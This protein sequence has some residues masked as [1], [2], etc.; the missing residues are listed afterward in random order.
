MMRALATP[1]YG[2][3]TAVP[4]QHHVGPSS[5]R[6]MRP[7]IVA[8]AENVREFFDFHVL[9]VCLCRCMALYRIIF[10][11]GQETPWHAEDR[12]MG[13]QRLLPFH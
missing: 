3:R 11:M 12:E 1:S 8:M 13:K 9:F 10:C 5:R 2:I 7:A 4:L 6:A